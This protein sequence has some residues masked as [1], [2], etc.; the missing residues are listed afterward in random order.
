MF[1][2]RIYFEYTAYK[3]YFQLFRFL[4]Y[5]FYWT[6]FKGICRETFLNKGFMKRFEQGFMKRFEQGFM[7]WVEQ[8]VYAMG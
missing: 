6:F 5:C 3:I 4:F 8:G 2:T 1:S 7:Q